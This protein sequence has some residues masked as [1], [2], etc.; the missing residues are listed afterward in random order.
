MIACGQV[1]ELK[2]QVEQ[3]SQQGDGMML[4]DVIGDHGDVT[5][6]LG[7]T[8]SAG[9]D[10]K[11]REK[12]RQI[13]RQDREKRRMTSVALHPVAVSC[14]TFPLIATLIADD[15]SRHLGDIVRCYASVAFSALIGLQC[16]DA[17]GWMT[18]RASGL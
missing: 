13:E 10:N 8:A 2:K 15:C 16:F 1:N 3:I 9:P 18:G 6:R 14:F 17:V 11:Q 5:F 4:E 12:I 7:F